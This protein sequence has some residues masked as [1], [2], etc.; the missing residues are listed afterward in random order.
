MKKTILF[1]TT[2]ISFIANAES[3]EEPVVNK[4]YSMVCRDDQRMKNGPLSEIAL[5]PTETGYEVVSTFIASRM[6]SVVDSGVWASGMNCRIDK[7]TKIAYCTTNNTETVVT[8]KE[9][10][11]SSFESVDPKSKKKVVKVIDFSLVN[12]GV[13]EKT[14]NFTADKCVVST[15]E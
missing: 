1:V 2:L 4:N 15:Q 3:T 10:K 9:T 7:P 14:M 11:E 5:I 6:S 8:V 13:V 12:K